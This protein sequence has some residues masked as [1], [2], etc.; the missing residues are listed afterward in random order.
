MKIKSYK[1]KKSNIYE[2]TL[3]NNDKI[4]L[5][6]DVILKYELLLKKEIN[7]QL[8]DEIIS[9][10]S[11]LESYNIALKYLNNTNL[12]VIDLGTGSG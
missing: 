9:F 8:L 3:S 4:S 11:N 6:D 7:K 5:Y 1:K 2:I 12:D 10:N